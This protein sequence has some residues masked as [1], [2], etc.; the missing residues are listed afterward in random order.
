MSK[1]RLGKFVHFALEL[2]QRESLV[3]RLA[4][5][6]RRGPKLRSLQGRPKKILIYLFVDFND[7]SLNQ[8]FQKKNEIFILEYLQSF[9]NV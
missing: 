6:Q 3:D 8:N 1:L 5:G 2:F 9:K 7:F 4:T